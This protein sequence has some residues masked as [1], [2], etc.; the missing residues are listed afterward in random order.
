[1]AAIVSKRYSHELDPEVRERLEAID[2]RREKTNAIVDGFIAGFDQWSCEELRWRIDKLHTVADSALEKGCKSF[3]EQLKLEAAKLE[4]YFKK[5]FP[6]AKSPEEK[7]SPM[8]DAAAQALI[9]L[10][11]P[12]KRRKL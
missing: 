9:A 11:N 6:P 10:R 2:K 4:A 5:A 12:I 3:S 1:M 7:P 8:R